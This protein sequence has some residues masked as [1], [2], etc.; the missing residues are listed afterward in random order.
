MARRVRR[1]GFSTS[2][3]SVAHW[4]NG[5]VGKKGSG[6]HRKLA[7]PALM[8][9]LAL[10]NREEVLDIGCG[11]GVLTPFITR[12]GARYTGVDL[13]DRLLGLAQRHHGRRG[14]FLQGDAC[15]LYGVKGL[16][17]G[18][19]DAVV[20]LLSLQNMARLESVFDS[21]SWVLRPGGRLVMLVMHP[22][23][24]LPRQ[25]G[26]GWDAKRRLQYRR[27]DRY[28]TPFHL[29]EKIVTRRGTGSTISFHRPLEDY[30][31]GLTSQ[32]LLV[33][34]IQEIPAFGIQNKGSKAEQRAH[35]EIPLFL[36][37][38]AI[39]VEVDEGA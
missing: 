5:W 39:K 16:R 26:W 35:K 20:F 37:S 27:V 18:M 25:S 21:A 32:G 31:N 15:D 36:G 3:D 6:H 7:V 22:C 14:R 11:Q 30:I 29:P 19:F 24:R 17:D 8:D 28:M 38:R 9:L 2:W 13:S 1:D 10:K 12:S 33:D 34:R 4:Y 23:F